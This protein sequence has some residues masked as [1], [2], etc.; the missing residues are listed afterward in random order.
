MKTGDNRFGATASITRPLCALYLCCFTSVASMRICDA[1]LPSLEAY[2]AVA[3]QHAART[4]SVFALTYGAAQL[5]FGP[6][7]DRIGK[8]RVVGICAAVSALGNLAASASGNID[9]LILARA[10]A[11]AMAAGIVPMTM[12]WIGDTVRYERRQEML[13]RLLGVTILGTIYGQWAGGT[14]ASLTGWR[15]AFFTT[16]AAFGA[17]GML[18]LTRASMQADRGRPAASPFW[19]NVVSVLRTPWARVV[20]VIAVLEGALAYGALAFLPTH[21]HEKLGFS[22]PQSGFAVGLYGVGGLFYSRAARLLRRHVAEAGFAVIGGVALLGSFGLLACQHERSV[23]L[24][25][26]FGAGFGFHVLHNTL[27]LNATQMS[28]DCRGTA[29]ALFSSF[30]FL[31]QSIGILSGAAIVQQRSTSILLL[32]SGAGLLGTA[33]IFSVLLIRRARCDGG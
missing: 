27:Q 1:M 19:R 13:A 11:G 16:A 33:V 22:M 4:I 3:P 31:G 30:L 28:T 20:L 14:I 24:L 21:F 10:A 12:A 6:L 2:F 32:A 18:T 9:Q 5:F 17:G 29:V 23:S 15:T 25:A 26:C 8:I 7:G